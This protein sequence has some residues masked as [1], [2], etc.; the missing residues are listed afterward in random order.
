MLIKHRE[1]AQRRQYSNQVK[2]AAVRSGTG[3]RMRLA[4]R[5][6]TIICHHG[7]AIF[8]ILRLL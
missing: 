3:K 5:S 4:L 2:A 8:R 7:M 1:R 6:V